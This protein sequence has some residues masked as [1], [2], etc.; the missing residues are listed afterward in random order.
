MSTVSYNGNEY[1][2]ATFEEAAQFVANY[3]PPSAMLR[4]DVASALGEMYGGDREVYDV[5][6]YKHDIEA[7][8]YRAKFQRQDIARRI[9]EKPAKDTWKRPPEVTD[10]PDN[11][12]EFDKAVE[13]LVDEHNLWNLLTRADIATGI[14]EYGIIFI[15]F[16]DGQPLD[17]PVNE[18]VISGIDDISYLSPFAQDR[19]VDWELGRDKDLDPSDPRYN[20]PVEYT[21]SFSDVDDDP[22]DED[23]WEDVHWTR[24]IHIA[25]NRVESDLKG[26]PRLEP[27]YNRLDDLEKVVGASAEMFWGGADRKLQ[28]DIDSD[29]ASNIPTSQLEG[30]D[31]E[32]SKLVHDMQSHIKTINTDVEVIG[33]EEPDPSGV[34][35]EILKFISGAKGI[36]QR[37]L[38]GSERGEL[39]SSQDRA[40]WFGNIESRQISFAEPEMLRA[41]L[42]RFI[43]FGAL[44]EPL[45]SIYDVNWPNLFELTEVEKAEVMNK[46]AQA[47]NKAAPSGN[48]DVLATTEQIID[49]VVDGDKPEPEETAEIPVN[50]SD[51]NVVDQ[52]EG[53]FTVE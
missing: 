5:L 17:E 24:V 6:G 31:D 16:A 27:V 52:F 44:P 7:T 2:Q 3:T 18:G 33:G 49:F 36:P 21:I 45:N 4:T 10:D 14:G 1:D 46:R 51:E 37:I 13:R 15:G 42:D 38:T 39:A 35:D 29:D 19:V 43:R 41:I 22:D 32:V 25:E 11:E 26:A 20:K 50:E 9:V 40:T 34:I 47:L 8:D 28:F 12:T 23:F 53:R 48:T 30:L